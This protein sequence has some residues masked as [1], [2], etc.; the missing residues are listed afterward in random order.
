MD[1]RAF[2]K[3]KDA[4]YEKTNSLSVWVSVG[5]HT[6]VAQNNH[7][8]KI[9]PRC[10][11]PL[12][13]ISQKAIHLAHGQF[14]ARRRQGPL[15]DKVPNSEFGPPAEK[16][17]GSGFDECAHFGGWRCRKALWGGGAVESAVSA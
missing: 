17:T 3:T 12:D 5:S 4:V 1:V 6:P 10:R 9:P 7:V 8:P 14:R 2:A 11:R 16:R 15:G 13:F